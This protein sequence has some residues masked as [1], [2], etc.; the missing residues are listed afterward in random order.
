MSHPLIN[1]KSQSRGNHRDQTPS[2]AIEALSFQSLTWRVVPWLLK[3]L[4]KNG[5]IQKTVV[6]ARRPSRI[7]IIIIVFIAPR[8]SGL[9][10]RSLRGGAR[11]YVEKTI[12][13]REDP[14]HPSTNIAYFA[15][16]RVR[17]GSQKFHTRPESPALHCNR[18][19]STCG[20]C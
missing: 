4:K 6:L 14:I 8:R 13:R 2:V 15:S 12:K 18:P 16:A 17:F 3:G 9:R 5:R 10:M 11:H 19:P 20:V 1:I 7:I